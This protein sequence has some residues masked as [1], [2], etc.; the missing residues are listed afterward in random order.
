MNDEQKS[1][2]G[3]EQPGD[4]TPTREQ[5]TVEQSAT[6]PAPQAPAPASSGTTPTRRILLTSG[7]GLA[8]AGGVIG[9]GIGHSTA[10]GGNDSRFQPSSQ[11]V[12]GEGRPDAGNGERERPSDGHRGR[13]FHNGD[14]GG[15]PSGES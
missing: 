12:P 3:D 5:D 10:D 1:A 2:A 11:F 8:L 14:A 13:H 4:T 9:F 15:R 6:E 7:A